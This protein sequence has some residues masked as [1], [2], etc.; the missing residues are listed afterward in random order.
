MTK[1][2]YIGVTTPIYNVTTEEITVTAD[3]ISSYFTVTNGIYYFK[4]NGSVFTT[5][6][7]GVGSS[8]ATTKLT[9]LYDIPLINFTYSYSS[10]SKYDKFTMKVAGQVVADGLSGATTTVEYSAT[11]LK[12]GDVIEFSYAKDANTNK[13]DDK[14]TFQNMTATVQKK[15]FVQN[16]AVARKVK[17]MYVGV[18]GIAKLIK[19][20]YFGVGNVAKLFF[21]WHFLEFLKTVYVAKDDYGMGQNSKYVLLAGGDPEKTG[22]WNQ[23]NTTGVKAFSSSLTL[24]DA[25]ELTE[26]GDYKTA[27]TIN[28]SII[29]AGGQHMADDSDD[30]YYLKTVDIYDANLTKTAGTNLQASRMEM[31]H[32]VLNSKYVFFSGGWSS[33]NSSKNKTDVFDNSFTHSNLTDLSFAGMGAAGACTSKHFIVAG[34]PGSSGGIT[35]ITTANGYD[36]S[37]TKVDVSDLTQARSDPCGISVNN[38]AVFCGGQG[39]WTSYK[40]IEGY[41]ASLTKVSLG[42]L[43][44]EMG[45][46]SAVVV[47]DKIII[48]HDTTLNIFDKKFTMIDVITIE[49][50]LQT[51]NN[52]L[53][54]LNN[55]VFV[56]D[57]KNIH[58]YKIN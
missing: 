25:P 43:S 3:N 30:R 52:S 42:N 55:Y 29:F 44:E 16:K 17:K 41:N 12:T 9:L 36:S 22:V 49:K 26:G 23:Y 28:D 54:Y 7:A 56:R 57:Y 32:G 14:C 40:S 19:K 46:P 51:G 6:N 24:T 39:Y 11:D 8:T 34:G 21:E 20:G 37:L 15:T 18:N 50:E 33:S 5:N 47:N 2:I 1:A 38:M 48:G 35:P 58:I 45:R 4:G 10:E 27:E 53:A 31:A 13:N